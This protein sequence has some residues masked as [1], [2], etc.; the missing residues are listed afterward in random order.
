MKNGQEYQDK[1]CIQLNKIK[2]HSHIKE[3]N[4]NLFSMMSL[5][6][7]SCFTKYEINIT[8]TV[9]SKTNIKISG[10]IK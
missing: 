4:R 2:V 6:Y 5:K 7:Y 10:I 9:R 1:Y 3:V 8:G